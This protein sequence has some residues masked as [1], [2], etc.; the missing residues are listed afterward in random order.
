MSL[1]VT[2]WAF[3][4]EEI[5]IEHTGNGKDISPPLEWSPGPEG[6]VCYA[7]IVDDPDGPRGS[8][9]HWVVY[10][11]PAATTSLKEDVAKDE[12]LHDGSV[13]GINDFKR[14]GYGGPHR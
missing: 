3:A 8:W 13:Q 12:R 7:V 9:V 14:H 4:L 5:P 2:S 1:D 6:T 10:N 11:L